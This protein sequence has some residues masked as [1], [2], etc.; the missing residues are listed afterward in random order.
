[1]PKRRKGAAKPKDLDRSQRESVQQYQE[2]TAE[3]RRKLLATLNPEAREFA[4]AEFA[5]LGLT[6]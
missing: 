1:M 3:N 2:R 4:I 5:K 6:Q